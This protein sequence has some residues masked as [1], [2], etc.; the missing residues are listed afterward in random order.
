[1]NWD[2][3]INITIAIVT[4][5]VGFIG[6]QIAHRNRKKQGP[7]KAISFCE[8]LQSIGVQCNPAEEE[9][10]ISKIGAPRFSSTKSIRLVKVTGKKFEWINVIGI[11]SQ[12][13]TTY[14]LDFLVRSPNLDIRKPKKTYLKKKRN[15]NRK[16]RPLKWTG[17]DS[18]AM[19]LNFDYGLE[20]L[21]QDSEFT[22]VIEIIP[23]PKHGY[24]RIRTPHTIPTAEFFE[25]INLIAG[26]VK[27][28][29]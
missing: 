10:E 8:Q 1:M 28:A 29:F 11:S 20:N 25:V 27:S 2:A 24:M 19:S 15:P 16:N 22:G 9:T 6:L 23:E 21:I 17:D 7:K 13:G 18:F 5:A 12:Y 14:Y 26:H 3:I 4:I